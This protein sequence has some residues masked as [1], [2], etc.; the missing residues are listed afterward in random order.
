MIKASVERI[1]LSTCW[2]CSLSD[3]WKRSVRHEAL[4]SQDGWSPCERSRRAFSS[5]WTA[6]SRGEM[7]GLQLAQFPERGPGRYIG[8]CWNRENWPRAWMPLTG[9]WRTAIIAPATAVVYV[10][11]QPSYSPGHV[12]ASSPE[13]IHGPLPDSPLILDGCHPTRAGEAFLGQQL[14]AFFGP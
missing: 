5:R 9:E 11:A 14:M 12:S 7:S 6:C 13:P 10:S 3:P 8:R 1:D 4:A 2:D